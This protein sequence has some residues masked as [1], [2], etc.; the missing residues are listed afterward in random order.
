MSKKS[1]KLFYDVV[2]PYSWIAFETLC[3]YRQ[4]WS[5]DLIFK[6]FFL[7]AIMKES[8]NS[9]P[10]FVKNKALYMYQDLQRLSKFYEIPLKTP[11]DL[12]KVMIEQGTLRAQ[13]LVTAVQLHQSDLVEA[14]SRELW[15]RIWSKREDIYEKASLKEALLK[16][17]L[18]ESTSD[19]LL[20]F[21]E[22]REVKDKLRST[23]K[24]ALDLKAFGSPMI[25]VND[26][27]GAEH[28]LFGSDRMELLASI[29][30]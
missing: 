30:G 8:G 26:E 2:S 22:T 29:I 27:N 4:K 10:M 6:P 9:P 7:G 18:N 3:R 21:A 15:L 20:N 25:L 24:E 11:Y 14:I 17:G 28:F 23:T 16:V 19:E 12:K 5:I 13:Q 1:V